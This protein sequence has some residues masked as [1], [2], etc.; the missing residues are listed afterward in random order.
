MHGVLKPQNIFV[1]IV[2]AF[3]VAIYIY[4]PKQPTQE[5]PVASS[6]SPHQAL[7]QTQ[8]WLPNLQPW[9][10]LGCLLLP[11]SSPH[12]IQTQYVLNQIP[13]SLSSIWIHLS[14]P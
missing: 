7:Q 2:F 9:N 5:R 11:N 14:L 10:Q 1:C 6:S 4:N 12:L 3:G 8:I 13:L